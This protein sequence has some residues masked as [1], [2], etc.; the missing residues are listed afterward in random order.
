M[1]DLDRPNLDWVTL[2]RGMGV[3]ATRVETMEDFNDRF[4]AS[5]IE[6]GPHLIE[7]IL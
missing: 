2:A 6:R 7:V 4:S 1:L 5:I 3:S